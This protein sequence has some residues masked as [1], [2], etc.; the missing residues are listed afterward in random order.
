M[1]ARTCKAIT[2]A[3]VRPIVP[4]FSFHAFSTSSLTA[5]DNRR[6]VGHSFTSGIRE[7]YK[8]SNIVW[9]V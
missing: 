5:V 4:D 6:P 3:W 2:P 1:A 8:S 9:R 7:R